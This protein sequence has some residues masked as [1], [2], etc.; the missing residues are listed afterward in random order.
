[1]HINKYISVGFALVLAGLVI[2][3]YEQSIFTVASAQQGNNLKIVGPDGSATPVVNEKGRLPLRVVDA[4]GQPVSDMTFESGSPEIARVEAATGMVTG[5]ERGF[6]TISARRGAQSVSAFIVVTRVAGSNGVRVP[7]D[8]K[9]DMGGRTYFSDPEK[10]LILKKNSDNAPVL[11]FAGRAGMSGR[12]DG[13]RSEALFAGP[14]SLSV[15]NSPQ[16][17]IYITDTLN[18]SI[19]KIDF[20]DRVSTILGNGSPGTNINNITPFE[21]AAF[22]GPLGV[23]VD[24]GGNLIIAD[25]QNHAIYIADLAKREVR[26]LA[27]QPGVAGRADGKGRTARF[28]RP[29]SI[30][31][32]KDGTAISVCDLGNKLMRLITRDG[33]VN[34]IGILSRSNREA[35]SLAANLESDGIV[36]ENPSSVSFDGV[37]NI[38]V[39]DDRG[40]FVITQPE[41]AP[42]VV[43]LAQPSVTFNQARSLVVR[44]TQTFVLDVRAATEAEAVKIVTVGAPR[45]AVIDPPVARIEG[46]LEVTIRG[47]NFAPESLVVLG[48]LV[49]D[50]ADTRVV[51]ATEIRFRVPAQNASG[52]KTL[53]VRTRGGLAQGELVIVPKPLSELKDGEIT[54]VAGGVPFIGDGGNPLSCTLAMPGGLTV[55][56]QGNLLLADIRNQRVRSINSSSNDIVT[57]AGNGLTSSDANPEGQNALA[58]NLTEP[59]D[60]AIDSQ[61]NFYTNNFTT[62]LRVDALTGIVKVVGN[63]ESV[64][65]FALD[66]RD[67]LFITD[68][69][70]HCVRRI[71]AVTG[72]ASIIAGTGLPGSGGDGGP[73][74]NA[75][76][77]VPSDIDIDSADNIFIAD[78]NNHRIRRIDAA[79]GVITTVA[80]Q[81]LDGFAGD[82]GLAVN[83]RLTAPRGVAVDSKGNLIIADTDNN[84]IRLVEGSSGNIR[85]IAGAGGPDG[86]SGDGGPATMALLNSPTRVAVDGNGIIYISD[87]QNNVVRRIDT[88]GIITTFVG[89]D[90]VDL[91]GDNIPALRSRLF[92]PFAIAF[93]LN[94]NLIIA[95]TMSGRIRRVDSNSQIIQT[96][97]GSQNQGE[98]GDDGPAI[99]AFLTFPL[100]LK[101]E[102]NGDLLVLDGG[103]VRR[104]VAADGTIR[105]VAGSRE[106][107]MNGDGI[108]ALEAVLSTPE[109]III[110]AAGNIFIA[111]ADSHRVRRVDAATGIITT[112]AG[113]G[114]SGFSGEDG[115]A[116]SAQLS[117]PTALAI[118]A[119]G[120]LFIGDS[121]NGRIR[122]IDAATGT[123]TTFAGNGRLGNGEQDGDGGHARDA[124]FSTRIGDLLFD[125]DGNLFVADTFFNRVRRI[126]SRGTITRVAGGNSGGGLTGDGGLAVN[127]TL[128]GP[129]GLAL[130][131]AGNLFIA[132]TGNDR[133][134]VVRAAARPGGNQLMITSAAFNKPEL[135]INGSGFGTAGARVMVNGRD[136]SSAIA[137]QN[138]TTIT[139]RGNKKRLNIR[140]GQNQLVVTVGG[141]TAN[142]TFNF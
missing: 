87:E 50:R 141:L 46:G 120:N 71:D 8:T 58:V 88:N 82:G 118:D 42:Q 7:G 116:R 69:N 5:V 70:C 63:S 15:D 96:I 89:S 19:R 32:N 45:I 40:A 44:G 79:T 97:A 52:N 139:L 24:T 65:A 13:P 35:N 115:P 93:D 128:R 20:N 133:I 137:S 92:Q 122:R 64:S 108:P 2:V 136:V 68:V 121:G 14:T 21:S 98:L 1:M 94:N 91:R 76:F 74:I 140:R 54:T 60:V 4:Q 55:D 10:S 131:S 107:M 41:T 25:T 30:A 126:D 75:Q 114:T 3:W 119:R 112:V 51:S 22:S 113:T 102:R 12:S 124:S 86:R 23:A 129:D 109:A 43:P 132:D 47:G 85:T 49:I 77:N 105:R 103:L 101:L 110:D 67:N 72:A 117:V 83:A 36:F 6:A 125:R 84:S 27:G 56:A 18:H 37:G 99:N 90:S 142:F 62:L 38:Y 123:I 111:E 17:G 57:I 78:R 9:S 134:R 130:D 81:G 53:S 66:S 59:L 29:G 104:I 16:G 127:A 73:A 61:G 31:I 28:S 33:D 34:T 100:S 48:D 106:S 138:S 135:T 80:G 26:L 11:P 95:D 39:V